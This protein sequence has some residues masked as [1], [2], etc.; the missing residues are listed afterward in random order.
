MSS[1]GTHLKTN[2]LATLNAEPE[3]SKTNSARM[4][5]SPQRQMLS[6]EPDNHR[7][8]KLGTLSRVRIGLLF[9]LDFEII[10]STGELYYHI[11]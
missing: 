4:R 5:A 9:V 10:K 3:M 7:N 6:K 11:R 8:L 2:M 1:I